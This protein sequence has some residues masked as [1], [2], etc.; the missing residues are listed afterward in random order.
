[1]KAQMHVLALSQAADTVELLDTLLVM[2]ASGDPA[3]PVGLSAVLDLDWTEV[4]DHCRVVHAIQKVWSVDVVFEPAA[5]GNVTR[6]LNARNLS[7]NQGTNKR[8]DTQNTDNR[9]QT[10][11]RNTQTSEL[12]TQH[13]ELSTQN[14]EL[15]TA[16]LQ[17]QCEQLLSMR[18]AASGFP[19]PVQAAI[20][21]K[22]ERRVFSPA[23]LE[24]EIE[25]ARNIAAAFGNGDAISGMG[26]PTYRTTPRVSSM[27]DTRDQV[28]A[29]YE[30]LMGLPPRAELRDVARLSGIRELYIGLTGD[31]ELRG[32]FR[33]EHALFAI[34]GAA[35]PV[36]STGMANL[37]ANV[38]NKLMLQGW[39]A[40]AREGYLW[41]K[42]AVQVGSFTSLQPTK[43][44]AA[45]G[46]GDIPTV[47]EGGV[48]GELSWDDKA[49]SINFVKKGG[50]VSLTLEMIDKDD[51]AAWRSV[52]FRLGTAAIRTISASVASVFA[53]N[54]I[55][56]ED[57]KNLFHL[58]HGNLIEHDLDAAGWELAV[59]AMFAQTEVSSG[60]RLGLRPDRVLAPI[61]KRAKA[62]K[63][64]FSDREPGGSLNDINTARFDATRDSEGPVIV[65]PDFTDA[66]DW[67]ALANPLIAPCVGAGFRFGETPEIFSAADPASYLMFYQ[68]ALPLKVRYFYAVGAVDYRAAV[69]ATGA[70]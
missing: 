12:V 69:K 14:S 15:G 53:D 47:A 67:V 68:D 17:A 38:M 49:E 5:G 21:S 60:K 54:P 56:G 13:S 2:R 7:T 64:F 10:T 3:P 55:I 40:M 29:A 44:L 20:R 19:L 50:F 59:Q 41:W 61:Q 16:L 4:G 25:S 1:M 18:L 51:S 11:E 58:D 28:E 22:F 42:R 36:T 8:M 34:G 46:F 52:G 37:T 33:P 24:S 65:V 43:W 45:G 70:Q 48:Y 35:S 31:R 57:A 6:V 26:N 62:M 32:I 9:A 30:R 66:D 39:D 63:L 27:F 23:E